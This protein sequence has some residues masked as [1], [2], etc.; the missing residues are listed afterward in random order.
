MTT[1]PFELRASATPPIVLSDLGPLAGLAGTWVGTGYNLIAVPAQAALFRLILNATNDHLT[2]TPIGGAVPN[3]GSEQ[4][5]IFLHGLTYLQRVSDSKTNAALHIEP[6]IWIN[7]PGTHLPQ[8]PNTI[9][10]LATIPHGD[11]VLA[12]GLG[13]T[14]QGAPV[15]PSVD[16]TPTGGGVTPTYLEPYRTTPLPPGFDIQNPNAALTNAIQGQTI[17]S[18]VVLQVSSTAVDSGILNIPFITVNAKAT[19][20]DATFWIETVEQPGGTPFMQLQYSQTIILHFFGI[21]W[22]HV[23]VGTL[24][25]Q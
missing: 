25:K 19:K 17:S 1:T 21:D 5:D 9:V 6:G 14:V 7:V 2:F 3:R 10:R 20:L 16:P 4:G 24:I 22:P 11:S 18:T 8:N 15:I 13:S 12:Q 23:T